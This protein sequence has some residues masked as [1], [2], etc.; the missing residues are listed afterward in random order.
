MDHFCVDDVIEYVSRRDR[1]QYFHHFYY[2]YFY[3]VAFKVDYCY[4]FY[5]GFVSWHFLTAW[6]ENLDLPSAWIKSSLSLYLCLEMLI[7]PPY[8][9]FV[10]G[11]AY[12]FISSLYLGFVK[13]F[14]FLQN[15][16]FHFFVCFVR[17]LY[18]FIYFPN[19]VINWNQTHSLFGLGKFYVIRSQ[20][21]NLNQNRD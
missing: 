9:K 20:E 16:V 5:I 6:S 19:R 13:M 11:C 2:I 18:I 7:C 21:K 14:Y 12:Q 10:A 17:Y 3:K 4:R 15:V 1:F 8:I